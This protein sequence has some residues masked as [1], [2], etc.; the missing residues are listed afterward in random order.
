MTR[1]ITAFSFPLPEAEVDFK[2]IEANE[3]G[4]I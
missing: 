3:L 1:E 4:A 2:A